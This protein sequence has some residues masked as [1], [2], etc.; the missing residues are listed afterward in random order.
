MEATA[1]GLLLIVAQISFN[2]CCQGSDETL[3]KYLQNF[4]AKQEVVE[5]YGG[6][7]GQYK[8]LL[9]LTCKVHAKDTANIEKIKAYSWN[10]VHSMAL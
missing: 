10:Q 2:N 3:A 4:R 8:A 5:H 6:E 7:I 9:N 1:C